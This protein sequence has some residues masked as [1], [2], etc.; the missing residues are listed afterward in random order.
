MFSLAGNLVTSSLV[1]WRGTAIAVT[2]PM[3]PEQPLHLYDIEGCPFCRLV[4]EVLTELDLDVVIYPCPKGGDRFRNRALEIGG[5]MQFP[6]L[7][8]P[9]RQEARYESRDIVQYLYS[10]Y[11]PGLVSGQRRIGIVRKAQAMLASATRLGAGSF[12][13]PARRPER[14]LELYSFESSPYT[15]P[16]RER[17][18]ELEISYVIR[19]CG[20]GQK[21]DY[22]LPAVRERLY[23]GYQPKARNRRSLMEKTGRVALPYLVDPNENVALYESDAIL[24]YLK[25]QYQI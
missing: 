4:R 23:P 11:G 16:V 22:L 8:D 15:R 19:N 18:C 21:E 5:K 13:R 9:N 14:L 20:K 24:D 3:V 7:V 2:E 25:R 17:L 12:A 1:L 6:L 10:H